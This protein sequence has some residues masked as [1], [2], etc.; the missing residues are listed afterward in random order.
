MPQLGG[1]NTFEQ[2]VSEA[3]LAG[4]QGTEVG[5]KYPTDPQVLKKAMDLRGLKIASQWFSSFLCEKPCENTPYNS[6][7]FKFQLWRN[8]IRYVEGKIGK[9][10]FLRVI[11]KFL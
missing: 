11:S 8:A 10:E 3:A 4:F 9:Q 7:R 1:Q 2:C 6:T 5:G